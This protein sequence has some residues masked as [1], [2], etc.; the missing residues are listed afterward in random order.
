MGECDGCDVYFDFRPEAVYVTGGER[1]AID[2][3]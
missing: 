2:A 3:A 1:R